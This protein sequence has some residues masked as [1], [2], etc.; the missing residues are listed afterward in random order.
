MTAGTWFEVGI[1]FV[2]PTAALIWVLLKLWRWFSPGAIRRPEGFL[3][4]IAE[5]LLVCVFVILVVLAWELFK[6]WRQPRPSAELHAPLSTELPRCRSG[7]F[8]A[9]LFLASSP[10]GPAEMAEPRRVDMSSGTGVVSPAVVATW[11][12]RE[13]PDG[14]PRLE[15]LVLWRGTPGWFMK[16]E[17]EGSSVS[18]SSQ[19]GGEDGRGVI[20][21]RLVYGSVR[22]DLEFD[23]R[24]RSVR[25]LDHDVSVEFDNVILVDNVDEADGPTIAATRRVEPEFP[26]SPGVHA[27][28]RRSPDLVEFLRCDARV[29]DSNAQPMFDA[30]CARVTGS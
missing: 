27:I 21:E 18:G 5:F 14:V 2:L 24:Q 19:A 22:L 1:G 15:L 12:V 26:E 7:V 23:Q 11:I 9:A 16:S 3:T 29:P 13:A 30:M 4:G 28:I 17:S 10:C 25:L 8:L 6:T 20:V